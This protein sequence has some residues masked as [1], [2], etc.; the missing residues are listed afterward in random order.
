MLTACFQTKWKLTCHLLAVANMNVAPL[1]EAAEDILTK[2][3]QQH[4]VEVAVENLMELQS[5]L[6]SWWHHQES[7]PSSSA[8]SSFFF[9]PLK[10]RKE[11]TWLERRPGAGLSLGFP[12]PL[13]SVPSE[14]RGSDRWQEARTLFPP[15]PPRPRRCGRAPRVLAPS[16]LKVAAPIS[17]FNYG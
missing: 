9:F 5:L 2:K 14:G 8:T 10:G 13:P 15:R 6:D 11:A 17:H 16:W 3:P 4:S 1:Q 7:P 12:P